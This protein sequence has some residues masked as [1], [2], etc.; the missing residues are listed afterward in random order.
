MVWIKIAAVSAI[1]VYGYRSVTRVN[2]IV[3]Q[4]KVP[5]HSLLD[6]YNTQTTNCYK[7]YKD[8]FK[9]E[10][11]PRFKLLKNTGSPNEILVSDLARYFFTCKIFQNLERPIIVAA[12]KLNDRRT[13]I[14]DE[15][16]KFRAFK[17]QKN[18]TVLVWKVIRREHNEILLK[19]EFGSLTG[20][21]WFCVPR[22]DNVLLF[23]S[24]VLIPRE[25]SSGKEEIYKKKPKELYIDAARTLPDKGVSLIS[26]ARSLFVNTSLSISLQVHRLYS[27][28]LLV[29]TYN[30]IL[31]QENIDKRRPEIPF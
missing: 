18:D 8:A 12:M 23:G 26:K 11:P 4:V 14:G 31:S 16:L 1:G 24:S 30:K 5:K 27:K 9:I 28:Y 13:I 10:L 22:D 21:S 20:T 7:E 17:F 15:V 3:K 2:Q 25:T 6:N 29:S 19:W